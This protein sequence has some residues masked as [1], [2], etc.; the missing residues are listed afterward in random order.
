MREK[1]LFTPFSCC[2][3][4]HVPQELCNKWEYNESNGRWKASD[5]DC[6]LDEIIMPM[7]AVGIQE[8]EHWMLESMMQ[9]AEEGKWEF[10]NSEHMHK[11]IGQQMKWGKVE[12]S[13]LIQVFYEFVN[14]LGV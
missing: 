11:W 5:R 10:G 12:I 7:V 9:W 2:T 3:F 4:C 8:G 13:R 14:H 1:R 6:Q